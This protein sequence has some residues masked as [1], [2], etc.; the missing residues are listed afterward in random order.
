MGHFI[1]FSSVSLLL[2]DSLCDQI[3]IIFSKRRT[4]RSEQPPHPQRGGRAQMF[5]RR[6]SQTGNGCISC[7]SS[8]CRTYTLFPGS[9]ATKPPSRSRA[10]TLSSLC[11]CGGVTSPAG[12]VLV[13][14]NKLFRL[15]NISNKVS[16]CCWRPCES[17]LRASS[18]SAGRGGGVR[19]G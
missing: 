11:V 14:V 16:L 6:R 4:M 7:S 1:Q 8:L 3:C 15:T 9:P 18:Q 17:A 13:C 19:A 10:A 5:P 12:S 2:I